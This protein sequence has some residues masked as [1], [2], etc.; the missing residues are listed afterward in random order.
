MWSV[1]IDRCQCLL[2]ESLEIE[3]GGAVLVHRADL[4]FRFVYVGT[5]KL[6]YC[7]GDSRN[8]AGKGVIGM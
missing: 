5:L 6:K 4:S 1:Y 2:Q 3:G 7:G 8:R